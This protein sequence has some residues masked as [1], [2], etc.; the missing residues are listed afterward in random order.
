MKALAEVYPVVV[1]LESMRRTYSVIQKQSDIEHNSVLR[2]LQRIADRVLAESH[3]RGSHLTFKGRGKA[4]NPAR[5][6]REVPKPVATPEPKASPVQSKQD[7]ETLITAYQANVTD[8]TWSMSDGVAASL[9]KL[10]DLK[11]LREAILGM[12]RCDDPEQDAQNSYDLLA[13]RA[14]QLALVIR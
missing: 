5:P 8:G 4:V 9:L 6:R 7:T 14:E 10:Y 3:A 11:T 12:P 1:I 2:A 13:W